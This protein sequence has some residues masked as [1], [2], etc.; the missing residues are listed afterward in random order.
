[1]ALTQKLSPSVSGDRC[2]CR[3]PRRL[4]VAAAPVRSQ[5]ARAVTVARAGTRVQTVIKETLSLEDFE[6]MLKEQPA[7]LVDF[8]ATW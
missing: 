6:A 8:Y 5:A 2:K 4:I 7:T 1:M 3:E